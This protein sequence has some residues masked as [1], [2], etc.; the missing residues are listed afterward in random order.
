M[1]RIAILGAGF[2]GGALTVPATDNGHTVALWGTHLDDHL[3][4]AVRA[5]AK[6]PKL[7]LVLPP[8]V[9]AVRL[10][11]AAAGA[12]GSGP[13]GLRGDLGRRTAGARAAPRP[14][15]RRACRC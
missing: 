8:G 6:H 5:G 15:S 11:R 12:R 3:I 1:A 4:A 2:M 7:G 13:G 14:A 9:T 10:D